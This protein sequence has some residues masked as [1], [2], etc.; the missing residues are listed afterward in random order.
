MT[1]QRDP[2]KIAHVINSIGLGGVPEAA[3]Q[4]LSRL[5]AGSYERHLM[6][7]R[8][9]D[10]GDA[11]RIAR[12]ERIKGLGVPVHFLKA[13]D[14]KLG[15]VTHMLEFLDRGSFDILHCHSYRPNLFARL[16][17][18]LMRRQGLTI[19]AHYHNQYDANWERD[20]TQALDREL[21]RATDAIIACSAAVGDHISERLDLP[22]SRVEVVFNGVESD[23][24]KARLDRNSA[25]MA[26]GLPRDRPIVT[27]V[28]RIS[29]QKNQIGL[30]RAAPKIL[31]RVPETVFVFA[32]DPDE[33]HHLD[34]LKRE[35][36]SRGLEQ[37]VVLAGFVTDMP[38]LYAATDVLAAPSLWEGF[39][40]MLVEAMAAGVPIVAAKVGGIPEVV[41]PGETA[42][43]IDPRDTE[44]LSQAI[45]TLL[46]SPGACET[47]SKA[48][49]S[50]AQR[51]TW[52]HAAS[53]VEDIYARVLRERSR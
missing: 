2:I 30:V 53:Q 8:E 32:G 1:A 3:V 22:R 50:R 33:A 27:L 20:G 52:A 29:E 48:G 39:G 51:F 47:M 18:T 31:C 5:P 28:G 11:A 34:A 25:R 37:S 13:S 41:V 15:A 9:L 38:A 44:G 6:V 23:R 12:Y 42:L 40:L 21:G 49:L 43:L 16:A 46:T 7:M 17:G 14:H 26:L 24:F 36:A 35:I 45:L 19:V 4:I 10:G